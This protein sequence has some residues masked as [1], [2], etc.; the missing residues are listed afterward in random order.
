M[1]HKYGIEVPTSVKHAIEIDWKNKNTFWADAL[2]KEMGNVCVAFEIL[3]Q[4]A[5]APPGWFKASG[6]K[7]R[8]HVELDVKVIYHL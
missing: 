3:G 4:N 1:S 7:P 8:N 2:K 5:K 6:A